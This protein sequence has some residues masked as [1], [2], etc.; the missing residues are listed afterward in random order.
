MRDSCTLIFAV[1]T[2]VTRHKNVLVLRRAVGWPSENNGMR[3]SPQW[4]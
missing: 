1:P 3:Q 2:I 4:C